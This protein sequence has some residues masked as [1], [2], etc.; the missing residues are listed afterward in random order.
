VTGVGDWFRW[1]DSAYGINL[2]IFYDSFDRTRFLVG[3]ATTIELSLACTALSVAVGI[4]GA[5]LQGAKS[6]WVR[7]AVRG[8]IE[9]FRNTPPLIQLLFFYFAIGTLLP[10]IADGAGG[11]RP[12]VS[13]TEWAIIS[14]SL[15]AGAHNV[16]I[17]R[18]G[19]DAVPPAMREAAASLGHTRLQIFFL[20]VFP[21]ALRI[22]FPAFNNNIVNLV[23]TTTLAYA[24]A[25]PELLYASAQIWSEDFNV[26]EMMNV[27]LVVYL[28]LIALV[29]WALNAI[30]RRMRVPGYNV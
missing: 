12:L 8:Y 1:L 11:S 23:K 6:P 13:N 3:L 18:S 17:F 2:P 16:E 20:I 9:F 29:V 24:I 7:A 10:T 30:E 15:F 21:L 27:L 5:W 22:S 26:K 4:F 25:V 14:F 28:L 19:I